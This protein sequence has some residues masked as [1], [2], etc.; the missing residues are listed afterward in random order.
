MLFFTL[1]GSLKDY[2]YAN[3]TY[4]EQYY[5]YNYPRQPGAIFNPVRYAVIIAHDFI[6]NYIPSFTGVAGL[7][8]YDPY[9]ITFAFS[10]VSLI[11]AAIM[12]KKYLLAA[13]VI[14]V[15]T[16]SSARGS[17]N[18]MKE[19]DYQI[20]M[21]VLLSAFSG[22]FAV[23]ALRQLINE[24]KRLTLQ[25]ISTSVVAVVLGLYLLST[26]ILLFQKMMNKFYPKYM[27]TM[28][29]IY[30]NPEIA[31]IVNKIVSPND[32]VYIGPFA[33]KELFYLKTRNQPSKYHWFLQHAAASKIKDE[34]IADLTRNRPMVIVFS[35]GYAPWGGNAYDF[36]YFMQDFLDKNYFRLYTLNLP[37]HNYRWKIGNTRNW[38]I[39]GDFNFDKNR[40][41]EILEKLFKAGLIEDTVKKT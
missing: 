14:Y 35:R 4:N 31:G 41:G 30:N 8:L 15:L 7:P 21:Y 23:S 22:M 2:F 40:Q 5:I 19:T 38:N 18:S 20:Y 24:E 36:N 10:G 1:T 6:N 34:L 29:L 3:F 25:K 16:F 37:D 12:K 33:F 11:F 26:G 27:G 9:V 28:P 39:D 13:M 32:Y 17:P